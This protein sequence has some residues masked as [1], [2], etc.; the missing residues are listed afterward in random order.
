VDCVEDEM[1]SPATAAL[2]SPD[3][4]S[5]RRMLTFFAIIAIAGVLMLAI[6]VA[7]GLVLLVVAEVFFA[8]AY[9]RFSR[10]TP[11]AR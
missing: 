5:V 1:G 10:R 7:I 3:R 6:S 8:I 9:R 11:P 4:R 2:S